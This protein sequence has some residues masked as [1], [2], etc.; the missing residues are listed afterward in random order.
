MNSQFL[1][2][3][4]PLSI[5][6]YNKATGVLSLDNY[7]GGMVVQPIN[8]LLEGIHQC[9]VRLGRIVIEGANTVKSRVLPVSIKSFEQFEKIS[10]GD[11][12]FQCSAILFGNSAR[13]KVTVLNQ[14][15]QLRLAEAEIIVA[16]L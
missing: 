5:Q 10:L 2:I 11:Y 8:L 16:L 6:D 15:Q 13:I 12:H 1:N 9:A 4:G 3:C 7:V 14:D